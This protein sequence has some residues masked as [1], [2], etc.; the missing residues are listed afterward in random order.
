MGME[1]C[2]EVPDWTNLRVFLLGSLWAAL[3]GLGSAAALVGD[4]LLANQTVSWPQIWRM[5]AYGVAAGVI[6]FARKHKALLTPCPPT[7][8]TPRPILDKKESEPMSYTPQFDNT[9]RML[10]N[11][12]DIGGINQELCLTR[13]SAITLAQIP[14]L[15]P[16]IESTADGHLSFD[17]SIIALSKPVVYLV[18]RGGAAE[19]AG[20]LG[21]KFL[22][23]ATEA[24]AIQ[25]CIEEIQG[26]FAANASGGFFIPTLTDVQPIPPAPVAP[27]APPPAPAPTTPVVG[28]KISP[29]PFA[30]PDRYVNL[31][32]LDA[33]K[34]SPFHAPDGSVYHAVEGG[35]IWGKTYWW[36]KKGH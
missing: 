23:S 18:F 15:A 36:V 6:A 9:V 2:P 31:A 35:G 28:N 24:L 20:N 27:P 29:D 17:N 25:A 7:S 11:G 21:A 34:Y 8:T 33:P 1:D 10:F 16:F 19:P 32:G 5:A 22:H 14:Q 3:M 12:Q 4:E 26:V 13:D 30:P